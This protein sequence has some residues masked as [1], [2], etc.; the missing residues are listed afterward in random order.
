VNNLIKKIEVAYLPTLQH[1]SL[2]DDVNLQELNEAYKFSVKY[3]FRSFCTY[4]YLIPFVKSSGNIRFCPVISFPE[5]TD[6]SQ[7]KLFDAGRAYELCKTSLSSEIDVVLHPELGQAIEDLHS[8][9]IAKIN[10]KMGIKYILELGH[11]KQSDIVGLLNLFHHKSLNKYSCRYVKTN[12]G[13]KGEISFKD[14]LNLVEWLRGHTDIPIKV[15]GNV[16]SFSEMDEY[17]KVAGNNTIFGVSYNKIT[18][19]EEF[20]NE[21]SI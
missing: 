14:K 13:K 15:S 21:K 12:T 20:Q 1:D 17:I 7:T 18:G 3:K 9:D 19:W 6:N 10:D 4:L 8:F 5:G 11:R 2:L 16:N